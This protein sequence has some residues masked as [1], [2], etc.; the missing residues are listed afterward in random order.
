MSKR[1]LALCSITA[2]AILSLVALVTWRFLPH[3]QREADTEHEFPSLK[4]DFTSNSKMVMDQEGTYQLIALDNLRY[5]EA[6]I[7]YQSSEPLS[8]QWEAW[9][10]EL[11]QGRGSL[12]QKITMADTLPANPAGEIISRPL[13]DLIFPNHL[14]PD[15]GYVDFFHLNLEFVKPPR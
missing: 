9:V 3:P 4:I 1:K 5:I 10:S 12:Q 14:V 8:G 6:K 2:A 15:S 7:A 11:R 13:T